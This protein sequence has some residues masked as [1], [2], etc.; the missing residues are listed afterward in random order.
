MKSTTRLR[1]Q[2]ISLVSLLF[3]T[4]SCYHY[5]ITTSKFDPSTG[6]QK[7]TAHA[8]F[9]GL[10]QKNVIATNCDSLNLKSLDEVR[11]TSNFGYSVITVATLGIWSP[12]QIEWKCPKPCPHEGEL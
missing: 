7:K 9:W 4:Q 12:V 3:F 5:R 1:I 8:F 6:Y 2:Q 10:V 11:I